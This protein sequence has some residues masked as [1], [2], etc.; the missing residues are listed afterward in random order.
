MSGEGVLVKKYVL[1]AG[2]IDSIPR[3]GDGGS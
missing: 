2:G 3:N 1:E